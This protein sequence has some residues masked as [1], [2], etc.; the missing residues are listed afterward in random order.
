[1]FLRLR[2]DTGK[3][4][5]LLILLCAV[6]AGAG[7]GQSPPI[8][9]LKLNLENPALDRG[10]TLRALEAALIARGDEEQKQQDFRKALASY[11]EALSLLEK[12]KDVAPSPGL[13]MNIG[14]V[15][16]ILGDY[17]RALAILL[18]ALAAAETAGDLKTIA[19]SS[20]LIGYCHRDMKNYD[21]ATTYFRQ[22]R[23][24]A[25]KA[26]DT[27]HVILAANEIGNVQV[28]LGQFDEAGAS[29]QEALTLARSHGDEGL[30]ASVLN[31]IGTLDVE[32]GRTAAALP[33]FEET[34]AI[35]RKLKQT[36]VIVIALQNLADV[37]SRLGRFDAARADLD[38]ALAL[39][40]KAGLENLSAETLR[41][42]SRIHEK[43]NDPASALAAQ[44]RYQ[45]LWE[46]L[47]T[48]EKTKQIAEMQTLYEVEKKQSENDLLR[49]EQ[50]LSALAYAKQRSQRNFLFFV[51]LLVMVLAGVLYRLFRQKARA[52]RE[53]ADA[54]EKIGAQQ[55]KLEEAYI[56]ANDL[57]RHDQLTGLPNRREA[58]EAIER[59]KIRFARGRKPFTLIMADINGFKT[60]NDT[61][62]HD[63]GDYLLKAVAGLFSRSIRGQDLVARWGG[64]E[65]L[66]LLPET[67]LEGARIFSDGILAKMAAVEFRFNG[68]PLDVGVSLGAAVY[69]S[70]T[71]TV[72][73]CLR[74][75]DQDMYRHKRERRA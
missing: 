10:A 67:G 70:E 3:K 36:R 30:L 53:L 65:F 68:Q 42:L 43:M 66:F 45:E 2:S 6:T 1:M 18:R 11:G 20:Y 7:R 44:R 34:L 48:R 15:N 49:R 21:Q 19:A 55:I 58:Q 17:D 28:L 14:R 16:V 29:K 23:D 35:G 13:F 59:E 47:F 22:A 74:E 24:F 60:I 12:F 5:L 71:Q 38:E 33:Y 26:G 56:R 27:G 41:L 8:E 54:N 69:D 46:R 40:D 4:F 52:N 62:G 32:R 25:L 50:E 37:R 9:K 61:V 73:T 72:E 63:A 39:S 51:A 75:A 57:A 31:D 64:D